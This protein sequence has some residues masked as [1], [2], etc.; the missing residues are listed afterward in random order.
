ML[1][2]LEDPQ[3]ARVLAVVEREYASIPS[4]Q[5]VDI[6]KELS[7]VIIGQF[8]EQ[9]RFEYA[10][11]MNEAKQHNDEEKE[12]HYLALLQKLHQRKHDT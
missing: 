12:F 10:M 4:E 8:L 7:R 11:K 5:R 3:K 9:L 6:L 2:V 1:P